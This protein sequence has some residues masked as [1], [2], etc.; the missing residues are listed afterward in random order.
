MLQTSTLYEQMR[1]TVVEWIDFAQPQWNQFKSI[2]QVKSFGKQE[3]ILLPGT[4]VHELYFVCNGLLRFYYITDEGT[5]FNKAFIAENTFAGSLAAYNLNLPV[6]YGVQALESTTLLT[7]K[8]DDFVA[9]FEQHPIFER[10]GRK[11]AEWLLIRK[12]LRARSL[13][14]QQAKDRYLDFVKQHPDLVKRVPQYHIASYLGITEVS[15][16]RL[17]RSL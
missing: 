10:L 3:Y 12:E 9:L 7:A 2:F 16:S 14:Q 8:F 1:T 11:F 15:L 6:L 17:K 13:L 5:E 4:K